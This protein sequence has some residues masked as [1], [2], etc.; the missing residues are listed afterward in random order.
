MHL[1]GRDG[2]LIEASPIAYEVDKRLGM[3]VLKLYTTPLRILAHDC[4]L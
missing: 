3:K 1:R 4:C 2:L